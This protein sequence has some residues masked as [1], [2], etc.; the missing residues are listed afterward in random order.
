MI[1]AKNYLHFTEGRYVLEI[2]IKIMEV[3]CKSGIEIQL[4]YNHRILRQ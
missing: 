3:E 1:Q 4:L 2:H